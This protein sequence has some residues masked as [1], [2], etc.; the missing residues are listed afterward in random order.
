LALRHDVR[1]GSLA[2]ITVPSRHVRFTPDSGHS[3]DGLTCPFCAISG[4]GASFEF[5]ECHEPRALWVDIGLSSLL[6]IATLYLPGPRFDLR[7]SATSAT[8]V[9]PPR[10]P[11]LAT[12]SRS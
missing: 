6:G 5:L 7:R 12:L 1:F 8:A 4:H 11:A 9:G 2:D 10:R 3:A